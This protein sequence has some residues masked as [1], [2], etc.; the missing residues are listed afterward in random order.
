MRSV[1]QDVSR[2]ELENLWLANQMDRKRAEG[3][4]RVPGGPAT[5]P[6][7]A[8]GISRFVKLRTPNEHHIGTLHEIMLP[9]GSVPHRHPK[10]YARRYCSRVRVP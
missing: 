4:L 1:I 3:L 10:D 6:R 7:Y 2:D 8:G 5:N 9:D